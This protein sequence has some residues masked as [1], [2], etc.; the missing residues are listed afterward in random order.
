MRRT[1]LYII[2]YMCVCLSLSARDLTFRGESLATALATLRDMHTTGS[3][4]KETTDA[5]KND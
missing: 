3:K 2:I 5:D 1:A 4:E